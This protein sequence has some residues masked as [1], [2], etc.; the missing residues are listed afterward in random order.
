M[1]ETTLTVEEISRISLGYNWTPDMSFD[2]FFNANTR[3]S[4]GESFEIFETLNMR[5][6]QHQYENK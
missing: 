5:Y 3:L 6:I 1:S 2:D 4:R